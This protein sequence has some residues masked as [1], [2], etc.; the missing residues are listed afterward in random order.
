[1]V[2]FCPQ[3]PLH[4]EMKMTTTFFEMQ[5]SLQHPTLL[6]LQNH[7]AHKVSCSDGLL[8]GDP[9]NTVPSHLQ[10]TLDACLNLPEMLLLYML[11]SL[12]CEQQNEQISTSS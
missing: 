8:G 4:V 2:G 7:E 12:L 11:E 10:P 1:M 9:W 6:A 5:G 3:A